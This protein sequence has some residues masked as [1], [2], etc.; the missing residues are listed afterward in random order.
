M[1][2][3]CEAFRGKQAQ[4]RAWDGIQ[5]FILCHSKG[6]RPKWVFLFHNIQI[7]EMEKGLLVLVGDLF[8]FQR[9]SRGVLLSESE[10]LRKRERDGFELCGSGGRR[11]RWS[12]RK[13]GHTNHCPGTS[14]GTSTYWDCKWPHLKGAGAPTLFVPNNMP[15]WFCTNGRKVVNFEIVSHRRH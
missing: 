10:G 7:N 4:V 12:R 13:L 1:I 11:V 2:C 14:R 6:S 5:L 3:F 15:P 8:L 9:W